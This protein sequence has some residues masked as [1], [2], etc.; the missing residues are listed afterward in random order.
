MR[1]AP[2]SFEPG[3]C[4]PRFTSEY[5]GGGAGGLLGEG[6]VAWRAEVVEVSSEPANW[7]PACDVVVASCTGIGAAAVVGL[8]ATRK[9]RRP[10]PNWRGMRRSGLGDGRE[11]VV[12][13]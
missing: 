5:V 2:G 1:V 12:E 7:P 11:I 10:V 6:E 13:P 9:G 4:E 3:E 8:S